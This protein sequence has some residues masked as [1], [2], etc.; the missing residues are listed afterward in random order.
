MTVALITGANSGIGRASAVYLARQ[1]L[2]VYGSVRSLDKAAKLQAMAGEAG[3]E[4]KVIEMDVVSDD[5]VRA[6][7]DQVISAAGQL[8]VLVNNAGIGGNGVTEFSTIDSYQEVMDVNVYGAIRCIQAVLPGM[9]EHGSGH[10]VNIT[11]IAG[12]IA[13]IAQAPYALSKRAAEAMSESLAQEVAPFGIRVSIIEPGITKSAIFAKNT[14]AP[15]QDAYPDHLRWMFQFY[16]NG[17]PQ[18]TPAE[19]VGRVIHHAITTDEPMLRYAVGDDAHAIVAG[20][21]AMT[22][23]QWVALGMAGSDEEY[24]AGFEHHFGLDIRPPS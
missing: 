23:E 15:G 5:S 14:E 12:V 11:S 8:D 24:Y 9:R 2:E 1:G 20:H 22:D 4:V 6:G 7:I 10:I 3:V 18:A 16:A 21:A 17:I 13:A 19:E